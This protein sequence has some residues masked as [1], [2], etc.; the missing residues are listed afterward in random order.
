MLPLFFVVADV[1]SQGRE[2][3]MVGDPTR[4]GSV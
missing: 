1:G 2:V 3:E 4:Q